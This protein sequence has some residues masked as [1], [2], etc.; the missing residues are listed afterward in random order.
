MIE[1]PRSISLDNMTHFNWGADRQEKQEQIR[2]SYGRYSFW[3]DFQESILKYTAAANREFDKHP[4]GFHVT[5]TE[6]TL[7]IALDL[8]QLNIL[9]SSF[10][11]EVFYAFKSDRLHQLRP[12]LAALC[13][14]GVFKP[15]DND[16]SIV[17]DITFWEESDLQSRSYSSLNREELARWPMSDRLA[18]WCLDVLIEGDREI[19][20]SYYH[21]RR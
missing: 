11:G 5:Q 12:N 19:C 15:S 3:R 2:R 8:F 17:P 21:A 7:E 13:L 1:S 4:L 10:T 18:R 16:V 20:P 14:N 9:H 6:G